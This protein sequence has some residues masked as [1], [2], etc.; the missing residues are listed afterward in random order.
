MDGHRVCSR[1]L[2]CLAKPLWGLAACVGVLL[3]LETRVQLA[4]WKNSETLFRRALAVTDRNYLAHN[5][6]GNVLDL[7]GRHKDAKWHYEATLRIRPDFAGTHYNLANVLTREGDF[8]AA[9]STIARP[10]A[11]QPNH[12]DA[13]HTRRAGCRGRVD[14]A[15]EHTARSSNLAFADAHNSRGNLFSSKAGRRSCAAYRAA[16]QIRPDFLDARLNLALTLQQAGQAAEAAQQYAEAVR[17]HPE[18]PRAHSDWGILLA[19][20]G[21]LSEAEHHLAEVVRLDPQSANARYNLGNVLLEQG[22]TGAAAAQYAEALRLNPG[23][24]QARQKLERLTSAA[25]PA[26]PRLPEPP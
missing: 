5:N 22:K 17:R 13:H 10:F 23:D 12:A 19:R 14:E 24:A 21:R 4:H 7:S 2:P 11:L 16:L 6:L 3:G 9:P 26:E 8:D 1:R 25:A 20:Q 15:L 18:S